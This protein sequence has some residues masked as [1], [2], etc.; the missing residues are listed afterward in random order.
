MLKIL[1]FKMILSNAGRMSATKEHGLIIYCQIS[2]FSQRF[3]TLPYV[4]MRNALLFNN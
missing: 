1:T 2:Q 3:Q 4:S